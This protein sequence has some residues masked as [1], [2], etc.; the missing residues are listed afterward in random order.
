[1]EQIADRYEAAGAPARPAEWGEDEQRSVRMSAERGTQQSVACE[2][3]E[4]E[5]E[6][7]S[8]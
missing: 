3:D 1:M 2:D 4:G 5:L 7:W 8:K 6:E